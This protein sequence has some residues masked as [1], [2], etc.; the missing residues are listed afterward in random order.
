[1]ITLS[2]DEK[3]THVL[4][5]S[6]SYLLALA[7]DISAEITVGPDNPVTVSTEHRV[8]DRTIVHTGSGPDVATASAAFN[9]AE[10]AESATLP[11]TI[12][13]SV[14]DAASVFAPKP[15]AGAPSIA[16][17]GPLPTAPVGT[18]APTSIPTPP[19]VPV[20][21]A[22]PT[23]S[24]GAPVAPPTASPAPGVELDTRGLP[25]DTRIHS[26][27][28]SKNAQGEWKNSRGIDPHLLARI[29]RELRN[30]MAVPA[31]ASAPVADVSAPAALV[32]TPPGATGAMSAFPSNM[33]PFPAL[34]MK[35]SAANA[36]NT[37]SQAEVL[38]AVRSAGLESLP[39]LISRPDLIP[40][41][42]AQIDAI[43]AANSMAR[44]A[45]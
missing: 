29:E 1:M 13:P 21:P 11:A 3:D 30:A 41:V 15:P 9:A 42:E 32:P 35:V 16:G 31:P 24:T 23:A 5:V 10:L 37:L 34:M 44:P 26:R 43:I 27:T 33:P 39:S 7:G 20:P 6:A 19:S 12:P 22:P 17:A 25:W 38:A 28:K 8:G 36:A 45:A 14:P 18:P 2:I 4:R 40:T